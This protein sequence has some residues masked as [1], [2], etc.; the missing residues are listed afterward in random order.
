ML[1]FMENQAFQDK[2]GDI[3]K[4]QSND[5]FSLFVPKGECP[6]T[7]RQFNLYHYFQLIKRVIEGRGFSTSI[8][9]GC[10]RGTISL[11]LNLYEYFNVAAF[12]IS[13]DAMNLARAN[14]DFHS[15][16][17]DLFVA[18]STKVSVPDAA[19]DL[20]VSI[21]LL[22]HLSNYEDTLREMYRVLKPGGMM[23]TMNIP[24][25]RS[26]QILNS[27][28][29]TILQVFG[30]GLTLRKDYFRVIDSPELFLKHAH[31]VGFV[32]CK[33]IHTNPFPLFTPVTQFVELFFAKFYNGIIKVRSLY[34]EEPIETG[35]RLAQCH[36]LIGI[37]K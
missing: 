16:K 30:F 22:E 32:D 8:E 19:Y 17:G 10:G 25:K 2:W 11:Y 18:E 12:D 36:F 33:I 24:K 21:G 31:N 6:K 1:A 15:G 34:K 13:E 37:K 35:H 23:I 26:V 9:F 27:L 28:Y 4:K 7:Q 14:F 5:E 3:V 29:R 20:V